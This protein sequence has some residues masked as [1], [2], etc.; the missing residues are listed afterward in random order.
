ME[1][2]EHADEAVAECPHRPRPEE[3]SRVCCCLGW[4][5]R[6]PPV[7][8]PPSPGC[9]HANTLLWEIDSQASVVGV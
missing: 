6:P 8:V 4:Q 1:G 9:V 5:Q 7:H 2:Q 3:D